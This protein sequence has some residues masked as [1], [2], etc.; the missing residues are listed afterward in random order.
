[1]GQSGQCCRTLTGADKSSLPYVVE[2]HATLWLLRS[3][4]YQWFS[5]H[6]WLVLHSVTK[7]DSPFLQ[8]ESNQC[9]WGKV[10]SWVLNQEGTGRGSAS[11]TWSLTLCHCR[12]VPWCHAALQRLSELQNWDHASLV[13]NGPNTKL[14]TCVPCDI[15]SE[16]LCTESGPCILLKSSGHVIKSNDS[17]LSLMLSSISFFKFLNG[18]S[19]P[20]KNGKLYVNQ[21]SSYHKNLNRHTLIR[22]TYSFAASY[23]IFLLKARCRM[24]PIQV[25]QMSS[26]S[27]SKWRAVVVCGILCWFS[28]VL[29]MQRWEKA[30]RH[31]R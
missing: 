13:T 22:D 11:L 1:M 17:M 6:N 12:C 18:C 20:Q 15:C 3:L 28:T 27:C 31:P 23:S 7:S 25:I 21:R 19:F 29:S 16:A 26:P 30:Y 5:F 8:E 9:R 14:G 24:R 2:R 4:R 10:T